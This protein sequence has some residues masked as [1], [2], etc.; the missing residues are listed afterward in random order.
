MSSGTIAALIGALV[1]WLLKS[2]ADVVS[3]SVTDR[4]QFRRVTFD[5]LRT[6]HVIAEYDRATTYFRLQRPDV[7]IFEPTRD[8]L[9]AMLLEKMKPLAAS[10][11]EAVA[12][13]GSVKP[14]TALEL[15]RAL[16]RIPR[17]FNG[18][19]QQAAYEQAE[20][21]KSLL[22]QS[23]ELIATAL[24]SLQQATRSTALR[25]GVMPWVRVRYWFSN[26]HGKGEREF[27]GG[28][29]SNRAVRDTIGGLGSEKLAKAFWAR[30]GHEE[31]EATEK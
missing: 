28:M 26:H 25:A 4:R 21:Y 19:L 2:L 15:D 13:L 1:G 5:L 10:L 9:E 20:V 29:E 23:D 17:M 16:T 31:S 3:W 7:E 14:T 6:Y 22:G 12:L 27:Q 11:T 8:S 30:F 24:L 18:V